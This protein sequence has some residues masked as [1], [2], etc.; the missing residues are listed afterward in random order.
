MG[1]RTIAAFR[2]MFAVVDQ[3]AKELRK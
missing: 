2:G 3:L 1:I